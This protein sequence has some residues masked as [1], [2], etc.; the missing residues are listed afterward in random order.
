MEL[1]ILPSDPVTCLDHLREVGISLFYSILGSSADT[2][3]VAL[4]SLNIIPPFRPASDYKVR[5]NVGPQMQ[6]LIVF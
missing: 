4:R 1:F 2:L 3:H 5:S 6:A